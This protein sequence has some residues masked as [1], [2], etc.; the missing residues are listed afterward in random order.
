[1][2]LRNKLI[3]SCAA[4]AAVATTAVSTTFA[5]YTSNTDVTATGITA[6]TESKGDD[7]LLISTTGHLGD[8]HSTVNLDVNQNLIPLALGKNGNGTSGSGDGVT[9]DLNLYKWNPNTDKVD[10]EA[11]VSE[12]GNF[13]EFVL[14]FKN[15]TATTA[16]SIYVNDL[17]ITNTTAL[18]NYKPKDILSAVD[19]NDVWGGFTGLKSAKASTYTFD[20][21][22][23]TDIMIQTKRV[24]GYVNTD[25]ADLANP[26]PGAS[27][28]SYTDAADA[29]AFT[30]YAILDTEA[31]HDYKVFND[32]LDAKRANDTNKDTGEYATAANAH[33]YYNAVKGTTIANT[34]PLATSSIATSGTTINLGTTTVDAGGATNRDIFEV[35]FTIFLNGWDL[36]CFNGVQGQKFTI[37][38]GFTT[39]ATSG[40]KY[41]TASAK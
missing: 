17:T 6:N 35:K 29:V 27:A 19:A 40:L 5:W 41:A 12:S 1:M 15:Q 39:S 32:V 31:S 14:Y 4:L 24:S 13:I 21:L 11:A 9:D 36:Q 34:N 16:Q 28:V 25:D 26:T 30:K 23:A 37:S 18:A 20:L 7:T 33:D 22:R 10:A 8:W 38:M 3:L 2:K